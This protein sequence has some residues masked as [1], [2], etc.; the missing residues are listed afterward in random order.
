MGYPRAWYKTL[1]ENPTKFG[2]GHGRS[3]SQWLRRSFH[4]MTQNTGCLLPATGPLLSD[5]APCKKTQLRLYGLSAYLSPRSFT[6]QDRISLSRGSFWNHLPLDGGG[7]NFW[8][9][10]C[11][12]K[13]PFSLSLRGPFSNPSS[14]RS[15]CILICIDPIEPHTVY[16]EH[17]F[18]PDGVQFPSPFLTFSPIIMKR[19]DSLRGAGVQRS[20]S[21]CWVIVASL[22]YSSYLLSALG[23]IMA[24]PRCPCSNFLNL[25]ICCDTW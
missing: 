2:E 11:L 1:R 15:I 24:P 23:K 7:V 6:G 3:M 14:W 25:W 19:M 16:Y 10:I 21:P 5:C 8:D 13:A 9:F 17:N 12:G 22:Q 20:S 18:L 4:R